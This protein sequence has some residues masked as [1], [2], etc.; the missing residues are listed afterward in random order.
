[1]AMERKP[2]IGKARSIHFTLRGGRKVSRRPVGTQ[3][4][5]D[6]RSLS[7]LLVT[8]TVKRI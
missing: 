1:M 6:D 5:P 3:L 2:R 7:V 8:A 4:T